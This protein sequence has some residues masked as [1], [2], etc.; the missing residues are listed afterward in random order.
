M[1][2]ARRSSKQMQMFADWYG[3]MPWD[4]VRDEWNRLGG[5]SISLTRVRQISDTAEQKIRE[6]FGEF[7]ALL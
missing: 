3:L 6:A 5:E 1:E 4:E 2:L 7:E